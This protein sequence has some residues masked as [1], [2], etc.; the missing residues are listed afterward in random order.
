MADF[1][2]KALKTGTRL[3]WYEVERICGHGGFGITYLA[4]DANTRSAVAIKEFLP[5]QLV[6]RGSGG[7]LPVLALVFDRLRLLLGL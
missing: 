4:R 6:D 5:A 7:A 1:D 2:L 3:F